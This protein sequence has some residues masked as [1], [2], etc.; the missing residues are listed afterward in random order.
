MTSSAGSV[1]VWSPDQRD[2]LYK[3][4]V[5]KLNERKHED[6]IGILQR[7]II[8]HPGLYNLLSSTDILL[9]GH[10]GVQMPPRLGPSHRR[11]PWR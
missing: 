11:L 8:P 10:L 1:S 9:L 3:E 2:A 5:T 4:G 6:A 7:V